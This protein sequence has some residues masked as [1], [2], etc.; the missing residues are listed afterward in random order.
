MASYPMSLIDFLLNSSKKSFETAKE[1]GDCGACSAGCCSHME[2]TA[3]QVSATFC[4]VCLAVESCCGCPLHYASEFEVKELERKGAPASA[5]IQAAA[6]RLPDTAQ[7]VDNVTL[8]VRYGLSCIF[9]Q[10]CCIPG[11]WDGRVDA[12]ACLKVA[13]KL[14]PGR[15]PYS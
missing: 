4:S 5:R 2:A 11:L 12:A 15:D 10:L 9:T 7:C 8:P 14:D 13:T 6:D 3:A 1:G